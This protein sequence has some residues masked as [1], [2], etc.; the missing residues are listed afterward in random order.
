MEIKYVRTNIDATVPYQVS[1]KA[2]GWDVTATEVLTLEEKPDYVVVKTGLKMQP[3]TGYKIRIVPRSSLTNTHWIIQNSPIL[4]DEDY[5]GEYE[6]RFRGLPTGGFINPTTGLNFTYDEFPYCSG[7]RVAQMYLEKV[8]P[9]TFE[10]V[11]ELQ[12]TARGE[13]GFGS[14]GK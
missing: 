12:K 1:E 7:D 9:I 10:E 3:P 4:G 5:T 8:I 2:G 11:D 6:I 14:T 13:S